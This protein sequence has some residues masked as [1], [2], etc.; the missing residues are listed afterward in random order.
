MGAQTADEL[1]KKGEVFDQKYEP[2]EALK[3]YLAADKLEPQSVRIMVRIARQYRHLMVGASSKEEKVRFGR[4][5]LTYAKPA[6]A[7][8]PNDAEAQLAVAITLGKLMPLLTSKEQVE[9]SPRLRT[10]VDKTLRLDARN[11]TAWHILGRWHRTLAEI[12]G[13]KRA[14]AGVVYGGL[15][16][17]SFEEAAKCLETA[18]AINPTRLMHSIELGRVYAQ[19]GRKDDARRV[20]AKGLA[21]PNLEIDDPETKERAREELKRLR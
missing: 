20:L 3:F 8:S 14:L 2:G 16:P 19:L 10:A 9:T 21:M 12:S 11:D 18:I 17:G 1:L 4:L 15:P 6:A 13:M 7:L 5:A